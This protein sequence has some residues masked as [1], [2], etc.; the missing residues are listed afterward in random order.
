MGCT[1]IA[2][3]IARNITL[4]ICLRAK[5]KQQKKKTSHYKIVQNNLTNKTRSFSFYIR[6]TIIC[7]KA[8]RRVI[9]KAS[10]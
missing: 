1:F 2:L 5:K 7:Y 4:K 8:L 6:R 9:D 3:Q 10:I